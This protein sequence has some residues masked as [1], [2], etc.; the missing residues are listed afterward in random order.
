MANKEIIKTF[1]CGFA[2]ATGFGSFIFVLL[3]LA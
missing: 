3:L 2:S 1:V